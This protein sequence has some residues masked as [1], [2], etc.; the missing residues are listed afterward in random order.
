MSSRSGVTTPAFW[1]DPEERS[2][3]GGGQL[4]TPL[5]HHLPKIPSA[6]LVNYDTEHEVVEP[7]AAIDA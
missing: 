2:E 1:N 4:Y 7:T 6:G 5:Y 3:G